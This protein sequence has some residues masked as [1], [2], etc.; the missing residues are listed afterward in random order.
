M[1]LLLSLCSMQLIAQDQSP[2]IFFTD[3]GTGKVHRS[4]LNGGASKVLAK[5]GFSNLRGIVAD[6]P[7]GKVYFA[8]NGSNKIYRVDL[9][10]TDLKVLVTGLGFPADLTMDRTGRK[11]Y[12]CDQQKSHIRRCNLDGTDVETVVKTSQ[13]YY[14]DIDSENG[15]LYWGTF[16]KQ[17]RI[18]RRKIDGGEVETLLEAPTAGLIQVRAVKFHREKNQLYWVDREAHKIQRGNLKDGKLTDIQDVYTG[19][20]TPHGMVLDPKGGTLYWCDTGTN[21]VR[22]SNGAHSVMRGS[23]DGKAKPVV[24]FSGSQPWDIDVFRPE[25]NSEK[26]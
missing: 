25:G 22:G 6:V 7:A 3:R 8:D 1:L 26:K 12:W 10:G 9:D 14:L 11:L 18:Y 20:D 17:G 2:A 24:V 13:P 4:D 21:R 15:H 16:F 19:L 23:L 5:I